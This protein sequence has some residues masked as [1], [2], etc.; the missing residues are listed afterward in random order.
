MLKLLLRR[1]AIAIP[2][3]LV[4]YTLV[5]AMAHAT[6]GSPWSAS[7]DRP[8][9]EEVQRNL[10]R[11]FHLDDPITVQYLSYLRNAL[12]GD[13][14]ISY[15]NRTQTVGQIITEFLPTSL[16][17]GLAALLLAVIVGLPL[18]ALAALRSGGWVDG[19]VSVFTTLGVALPTYVITSVL[20]V[21]LG[22]MLGLVPT[23]GWSG[24]FSSS[25][26]V[27]V[28]ALSMAPMA[29][30]TRYFRSSMLDTLHS[31][32]V[33]TARAKGVPARWILVRH[34]ARNALIPV[35][36]VLGI[37]ASLVLVGSFFVETIAGVPGLGH[38]FVLSITQRDYPVIMGTTLLFATV[39]LVLNTL[40]DV[41]YLFIDPRIRLGS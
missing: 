33:R 37:Y 10:D 16:Q 3:L 18:G 26:L 31:D 27:P 11:E 5:F 8:V 30:V 28:L 32:Y 7:S 34:M 2:T 23:V 24:I 36:T 13:F 29:G 15:Q 41:C 17:L 14:G 40:V 6:P 20:I 1:V 38:E 9:P 25:A 21:V 12:Q 39:V 4:V 19:A 35:V 22:S